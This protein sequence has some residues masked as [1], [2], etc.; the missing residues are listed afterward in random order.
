MV[1]L[2]S[3]HLAR[4]WAQPRSVLSS[5]RVPPSRFRLLFRTWTGTHPSDTVVLGHSIASWRAAPWFPLFGTARVPSL[6]SNPTWRRQSAG[7]ESTPIFPVGVRRSTQPRL[8]PT[9]PEEVDARRRGFDTRT[10]NRPA[11]TPQRKEQ[12]HDE[13]DQ[14]DRS[15]TDVHGKSPFFARSLHHDP[16]T[17]EHAPC[18][19]GA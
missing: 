18:H 11:P 14:D 5:G 17:G 3:L 10:L 12:Q 16:R 7:V 19:T 13:Q 1:A 15:D 8:R 9:G 4:R 6:P 2:D